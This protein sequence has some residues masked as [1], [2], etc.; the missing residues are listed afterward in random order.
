MQLLVIRHGKAEERAPDGSDA[1]RA[2]TTAGEK[3]M[4]AISAGL[5][6]L[7]ETIDMIGTSPLLRARQTASVVAKAYGVPVQTV[8]ALSPGGEPP[9]LIEWLSQHPSAESVALVGHEPDLGTLVT[10]LMTKAG[11]SRVELK[12]GGAALLEFPGRAAAGGGTL[13]WLLTG[14]QLRRM[15]S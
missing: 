4:Q 5:R 3:E 6:T 9:A 7:V 15:E 1:G 8:E 13:L 11:N 12:K 14:S 2:L 10:W